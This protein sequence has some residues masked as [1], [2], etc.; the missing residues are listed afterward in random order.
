MDVSKAANLKLKTSAT[1]KKK[2]AGRTARLKSSSRY[3]CATRS[4]RISN[5]KLQEKPDNVIDQE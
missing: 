5:S 2:S 3:E 4:I 1:T